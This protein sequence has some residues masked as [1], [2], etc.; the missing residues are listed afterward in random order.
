MTPGEFREFAKTMR[1][2]GIARVK[3][4]DI[5]LTLTELEPAKVA[6]PAI[7]EAPISKISGISNALA[8]FP[9]PDEP[10]KH[11][12]EQLSSLL[13]LSDHE[14]VDEL[15]PDNDPTLQESVG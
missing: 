8:P 2:F 5:E 9:Q 1:E 12:M 7:E 10:I 13:K 14:L 6:N 3:T 4:R 15:F 11:K